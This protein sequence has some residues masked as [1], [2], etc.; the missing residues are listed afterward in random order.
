MPEDPLAAKVLL[1]S[2]VLLFTSAFLMT[3]MF[4]VW[5]QWL[6]IIPAIVVLVKIFT[7][8]K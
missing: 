6:A 1:V 8:R 4:G 5:G 2:I 7:P 3:C